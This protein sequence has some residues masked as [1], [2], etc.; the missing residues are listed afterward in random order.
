MYAYVYSNMLTPTG[1][2]DSHY[3]RLHVL[4]ILCRY[5]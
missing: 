1:E 4:T 5:R 3:P 2:H